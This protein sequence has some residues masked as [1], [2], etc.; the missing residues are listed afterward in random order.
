MN[1]YL[2]FLKF[3]SLPT[4]HQEVSNIR[5]KLHRIIFFIQGLFNL[6]LNFRPHADVILLNNS[7]IILQLFNS[8]QHE[9]LEYWKMYF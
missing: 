4:Q 1:F 3:V 5:K 8:T 6:T 9:W 2:R 7:I